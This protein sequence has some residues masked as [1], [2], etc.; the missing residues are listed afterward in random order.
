LH[1]EQLKQQQV[2]ITDFH[3]CHKK[4]L[5]QFHV[6]EAEAKANESPLDSEDDIKLFTQ[7]VDFVFEQCI[8]QSTLGMH[9]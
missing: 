7:H 1:K 4:L 6:K 8:E 9:T 3:E 5:A 2:K